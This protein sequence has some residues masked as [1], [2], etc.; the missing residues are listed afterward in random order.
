MTQPTINI[1]VPIKFTSLLEDA[2]YYVYY[3]GRGSS[4]SWSIAQYLI[5][6]ALSRPIK[7]LCTRELQNSITESVH[8][9]LSGII[10]KY[11]LEQYFKIKAA[12]IETSNGSTFIF[13]GLAHNIDSVKSTEGVDICWVEEADKVSQNSWDILIPTIRK[14]RSKFLITFNPTFDDDPVYDMFIIK[15]MHRAILTKVNWQDNPHFPEVLRLEMEHMKETDYDKYCHVWEGDLRTISDAQVFKG[16]TIVKDFSSEGVEVFYHGMDFGFAKDPTT[17]I[18]C[19]IRGEDLYIDR[20][21]YGH[22]IELP[23]IPAMI[24]A[25]LHGNEVMRWQIKADCAR[26]E[27]ISYLSNK[28][29]NVIGAKKWQGSVE[30]GIEYLRGFKKI[31]IHPSCKKTAEEFKRYSYK[32]DKRTNEILPI[33]IDDYNHC[34]D[35]L[36]YSIDNLIKRKTSIYDHGVI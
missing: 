23:D 31:Y 17:I 32:I 10:G 4:K 5:V 21:Q 11:K 36:R 1:D 2:R 16:K 9:L 30:D 25:I 8:S 18:R 33:V 7:I 29:Y 6:E 28:N 12:T 24:R 35:A 34:I 26:P 14:P 20:E 3:G 27:T 15:G 19:F 13:K 22:H